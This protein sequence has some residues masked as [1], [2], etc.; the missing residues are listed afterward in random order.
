LLSAILVAVG[1]AARRGAG[2]TPEFERTE[3]PPRIPLVTVFT[4]HLRALSLTFGLSMGYN[5]IAYLGFSFFLTYALAVGHTQAQSLAAQAIFLTGTTV[6][7]FVSGGLA[8][9]FG[10]RPVVCTGALLTGIYLFAFFWMVH[11]G[12]DFLFYLAFALASPLTASMKGTT[13]AMIAE[14]FP[15]QVRYSGASLGYQLGAALGGGLAPT[16]ATL[17]FVS[18]GKASWSVPLLGA[19]VA[20]LVLICAALLPETAP[21]RIGESAQSIPEV[22]K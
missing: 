10:R 20:L 2:D 11:E 21:R 17:V 6:F 7:S 16:L 18:S 19:G 8:D 9:R 22:V 12:N 1:L 4:E 5:A 13:P 14:Q 3:R 15:A